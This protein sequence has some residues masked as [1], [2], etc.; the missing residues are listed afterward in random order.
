MG[1]DWQEL[2]DMQDGVVTTAQ[3]LAHG[4]TEK[5]VRHR[6]QSGQWVRALF[7]VLVVTNGALT[8]DQQLRAALLYGGAGALLSHHS[9]A[10]EWGMSRATAGPVHVTR[11]YGA[12]SV[13][14]PSRTRPTTPRPTGSGLALVHPGVVVH[15]S[16]ALRHIGVDG[17][18]PRTSAADTVLDL[19]QSAPNP[20]AAMCV[21]VDAMSSGR[22]QPSTMR[23]RIEYRR[24]RRYLR[25]IC[26]TLDML[27]SGVHS[28]LE[29][30]YVL[31]VEDAHGLPHG[32]RQ[33]PHVVD[34]R[35]L[36]EDLDYSPDG[37]P[38]IVR[39]DGQEFH[40]AVQ[41]RFRDR[42]R[43]NASELEKRPRLSYGWDDVTGDPC[44]VYREVRAVLVREGWPDLS[45]PCARCSPLCAISAPGGH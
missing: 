3:A 2:L 11:R 19:A 14:A 34:G 35:V 10:E 39:L 42:R 18:L 22:V 37:V 26:R 13:S 6:T 20:R 1:D 23:R 30:R 12:S 27:E 16:R 33:A 25:A 44:G 5:G 36:F 31:D 41:R 28:V 29:H 24:P 4:F 21:A 40:T 8:R 7:G 45:H 32:R 15:R 9:A 43:D 38:L 17:E